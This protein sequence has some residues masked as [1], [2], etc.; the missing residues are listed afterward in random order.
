VS[1]VDSDPLHRPVVFQMGSVP[2]AGAGPRRWDRRIGQAVGAAVVCGALVLG[3][4]AGALAGAAVLE[5]ADPA[6]TVV[7]H[8]AGPGDR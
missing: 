1:P 4:A 3:S 8:E 6:V 2:R 5:W 7:P